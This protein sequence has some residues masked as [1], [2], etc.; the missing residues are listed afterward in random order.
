MAERKVIHKVFFIWDWEGEEIWLNNMAHHGWQLEKVGFCR[1]T[2]VK[3]EPDQYQYRLQALSGYPSTAESQEYIGFVEST[4][5]E[6]VDTFLYWAYFRQAAADGP[7]ELFSDVDSR[8]KHMK[9]IRQVLA[10]LLPLIVLNFINLTRCI[11]CYDDA[12]TPF[13]ILLFVFYACLFMPLFCYGF[14]RIQQKITRLQAE[15]TLHE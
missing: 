11:I 2:F 10:V 12:R 8:V 7:F 6:L 13:F 4:G 1:Y 15:G 9:R 14:I 3:G 5:A